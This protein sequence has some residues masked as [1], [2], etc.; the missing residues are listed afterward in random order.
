MERDD[1]NDG[2]PLSTRSSSAIAVR[3]DSLLAET[4][5]G[6]QE[7]LPE[8]VR[9]VQENSHQ[10]PSVFW[11]RLLFFW[12]RIYKY[13]HVANEKSSVLDL[14]IPV[15]LPLIGALFQQKLSWSQ[16]FRF[17]EES[18]R[19]QGVPPERFLESCMPLE[20]V[21]MY[22]GKNEKEELLVIGLD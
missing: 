13:E 12:L 15:P 11:R 22:E 8:I 3:S 10:G 21:R 16:A 5:Q 1:Q 19:P 9:Q 18:R 17:I 2:R 7:T 4:R 14:R 6:R 20:F